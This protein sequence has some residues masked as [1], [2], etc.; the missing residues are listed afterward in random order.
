VKNVIIVNDHAFVNGGQAKVAIETALALSLAGMA[1]T[2]FGG[3]GPVDT[4]LRKAGIN[5][6]CLDQHDLLDDPKRGR[7]ALRGLWNR[8]AADALTGLLAD[9]DPRESIVHIHGW[10]KSLS[11]SIGAVVAKGRIPHVYTMHEYFLA[12]PNGGFYDRQHHAICE[13]RPLGTGCLTTHCDAR[14]R[15]HKAWRV[16]RQAVLWSAGAMPRALHDLIYISQTQLRAM[17]Q[18]LPPQAR[19]HYLPNPV[20]PLDGD[21]VAAEQNRLFLF[22]G[23]LSPEKGAEIAARAA[24]EASVEIAFAGEGECRPAIVSANPDARI[25]GWLHS[26]ALASVLAKARCLVFP[27]LW[28]EGFPMAVVE[29]MRLGLPVLA[30]DKSAA[31]EV[32]RHDRD[33]LHVAIGDVGAWVQAMRSLS[34]NERVARYSRSSFEAAKTFIT[35]DTYRSRLMTIYDTAALAQRGESSNRTIRWFQ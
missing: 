14:S 18:Y 32:V 16:A 27:S 25:M 34:D 6:V 31:A 11:P 9:L 26:D 30:A 3:V 23:R 22:V 17:R 13:R 21:R 7:A 5:C 12:C 24:R 8:T 29:A 20:D 15:A 28:Y 2:F 19:L 10:A 1:V 33:G 35:P 4:R